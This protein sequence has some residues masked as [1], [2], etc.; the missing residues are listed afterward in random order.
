MDLR[1]PLLAGLALAALPALAAADID[2]RAERARI[3]SERA[4][5]EARHAADEAECR[6]RFL[7]TRCLEEAKARRREGLERLRHEELVLDDDARRRRAAARLEAIEARQRELAA[8]PPAPAQPEPVIREAAQPPA[9][10]LPGYPV[11]DGAARREAEAA[12]AARRAEA[13]ERRREQAAADR[14]R[15]AAREAERA[16]R[17]KAA[18]PLPPRPAIPQD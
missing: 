6:G 4:A 1:R 7:V 3:A 10:P 9:A 12:K 14:E 15:I 13:A 2:E 16:A 5:V 8:R 11:D 18:E 17:G